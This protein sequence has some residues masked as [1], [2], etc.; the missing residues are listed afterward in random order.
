MTDDGGY[1]TSV[2]YTNLPDFGF[3]NCELWSRTEFAIRFSISHTH[4]K[5]NEPRSKLKKS[6][7][8]WRAFAHRHSRTG[9]DRVV[10]FSRFVFFGSPW[11]ICVRHFHGIGTPETLK[12]IRFHGNF[13][14]PC[15]VW[16]CSTNPFPREWRKR[17]V[18]ICFPY[19]NSHLLGLWESGRSR[20]HAGAIYRLCVAKLDEFE[21]VLCN[22][23]ASTSN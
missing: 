11:P 5:P 16:A 6:R 7:C 22:Q 19:L 18:Y 1:I 2:F 17:C 8:R 21:F 10:C 15:A 20:V 23:I 4:T 13:P 14:L 12:F 3:A 9:K